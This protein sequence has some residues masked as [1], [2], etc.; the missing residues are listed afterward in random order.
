MKKTISKLIFMGLLSIFFKSNSQE[1]N[2]IYNL[3]FTSIEGEKV[4]LETFKGKYIL[5]V[6]VASKCGFT[7]QYKGLQ[8]LANT[9]KEQLVLKLFFSCDQFGGQEPGN[10]EEIL[11][12]CEARYGVT[13]TLSEK[14]DVRGSEQHEIYAWLTDKKRNGIS[15][16]SVTW[17][18]QK[19][20]ISPEGKFIEYFFSVTKPLSEKIISNFE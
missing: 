6:N 4:S 1:L 2:S 18:F 17:N 12:F 13:F 16:N 11:N 15:S 8:K 19:Y 20:L 3:S 9:Y 5:F 10:S 7:T 14:I